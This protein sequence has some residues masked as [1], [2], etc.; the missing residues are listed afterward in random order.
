MIVGGTEASITQF[1][2]N[3]FANMKALSTRNETPKTAS[4]PF[5]K[6]RDGFVMGEGAGIL[7]LEELESAL[8]RGAKIYAEMVGYGETCD[9]N[10]ITAPIE[11]GE[12]ATKA[13]RIALKD[14]NL[15]LDD[16]TYI[17]AHGTSTPTNDVVET[18]A[19]KALFG[20]KAK[21]LYISSTKG[22][23]GHGLGAAGGIEGVIIAKAIADGVIPPTINLHETEEE[24]DLNYVPNQAIKTDVK[25]AMSNSLGFGGHNS[26]IVMKKFEK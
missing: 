8:A 1:C 11:T 3:S 12:G 26:V 20:D 10:H 17:N 5:S 24:C 25:V 16:V 4:R 2:I 19:I 6:D 21:D 13:M 15:S 23:T 22:A 7:I 18:R 9:A 14:A